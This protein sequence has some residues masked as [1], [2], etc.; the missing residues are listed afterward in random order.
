[1]LLKNKFNEE[2]IKR[3]YDWIL[4]FIDS[5][6]PSHLKMIEYDEEGGYKA[7]EIIY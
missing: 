5:W 6:L 3:S 4:R 2:F 7:M 1:M